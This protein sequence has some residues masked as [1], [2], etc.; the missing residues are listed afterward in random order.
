MTSNTMSKLFRPISVVIS[1]SLVAIGL[2]GCPG[3]TLRCEIGLQDSAQKPP[4][5]IAAVMAPTSNFVDFDSIIS[6]ASSEI[7]KDLGQT[8]DEADLPK[9]K[10]RELSI[11]LGDGSPKLAARNWVDPQG[12]AKYDYE[13]AIDTTF[14]NFD[15]VS[16]CAAGDLKKPHDQIPTTEESDLLA[17]LSVAVDQ[18]SDNNAEKKIYI[19][20]NGIQTAGAIQMQEKGRF[21]KSEKYATQLAQGLEDIGALPDLNGTRVIWYGLGQVDGVEQK[22]DQKSSDSL[23]YFWQEVISRSNGT[24]TLEDIHGKVGSGKPHKNAIKVSTF[25]PSVCKLIIKLYEDDGV[26]FK[27]DSNVFVDSPKAKKAAKDVVDSFKQAG[28]DE[29]TVHG[30]A[31][32]GVDKAKYDADKASIDAENKDLTLSRAKAFRNLLK[33]AGFEG[34]INT[35]GEGTCGTEWKSNGKVAPDLQKLCRRVEVSN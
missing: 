28:C 2:T 17:G 26:Q 14:S 24:L 32:A 31:A 23:I 9:A 35:S 19:L 13:S 4:V 34:T 29:M 6:A 22:L 30:Y 18:L 15:L 10:G 8:S 7:K 5:Q 25:E 1:A 21:P 27:P 16:L 12:D 11:V 20:G 3:P 33:S